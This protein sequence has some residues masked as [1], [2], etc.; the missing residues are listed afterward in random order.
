[1]NILIIGGTGTISSAVVKKS[2]DLGYDVTVLNRGN[3]NHTLPQN[4]NLII[5]DIN[6]EDQIKSLLKGKIYDSVIQFVGFSRNQIEKDVRIFKGMTRQYVFISSASVYHKPV[7]DYPITEETPLHNPHWS[8]SQDKIACEQYLKTVKDMNITIVRPS[9]TYNCQMI[10]APVIRWGFEY[11]HIKR[12]L[13][14]KPIIIPGDGTSLWTITHARDFAN[15]F[16]DLLGNPKTYNQDF[17]ITS[18][19]LYTWDQLTHI[20]AKALGVKANIVHIPTDF[21]IRTLP[22]LEGP[23]LGDKTWSAIFD[24]GKIKSISENYQSSIVYEDI[25]ADVLAFYNKHQE[26][27][28][29]SQEFEEKYDKIISDY[30]NK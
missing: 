28:K 22:E 20:T 26:K 5:G 17:H 13:E 12:L 23:L 19:K 6:E 25:V 30:L 10:M 27:Q 14:R 1:M 8:Y 11:A 24:N 21:I 9:H 7:E 2:V 4:V 18:E 3:Q 16:V 29:V 15:S